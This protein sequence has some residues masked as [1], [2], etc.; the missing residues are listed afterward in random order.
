ML[1]FAF[2]NFCPYN[3]F[4]SEFRYC[5]AKKKADVKPVKI[6]TLLALRGHTTNAQWKQNI[7]IK[8]L[9][10]SLLFGL[11]K[12]ILR[13]KFIPSLC[14]CCWIG[15]DPFGHYYYIT[16][17]DLEVGRNQKIFIKMVNR[18][19]YYRVLFVCYYCKIC[20][21]RHRFWLYV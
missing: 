12:M 10:K 2:F 6:V 15:F 16:A 13:L 3:F 20:S 21:H 9:Q 7:L 17:I 4:P 11:M 19:V 8:L 14:N 1:Y 5:F 18:N